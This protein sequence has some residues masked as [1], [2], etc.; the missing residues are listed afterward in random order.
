MTFRA[1]ILPLC[2]MFVLSQGTASVSAPPQVEVL[3]STA[4]VKVRDETIATVAKGEKYRLV[5][6]Q[7]PWVA[8]AIGNGEKQKQGWILASAVK[9]VADPNVTEESTAPDEPVEIRLT[10]DLTQFSTA[11]G[12]EAGVFFKARVTN[13]TAEPVQ[14]RVADLELK[15]DD[16]TLPALRLNQH[17]YYSVFLDAAMRT[18]LQP[19]ALP[20]LN[21]VQLAPGGVAEGWMAY[22]LSSLQQSLAQPGALASKTWIVDGKIGPHRIHLDLKAAEL[23]LL[24]EQARPSKV[25]NSVLVIDIGSRINAINE[26]RLFELIASVP[27]A[28]CG[29]VL[30]LKDRECLVDG[31][32]MQHF[33]QQIRQINQGQNLPVVSTEGR[34]EDYQSHRTFVSSLTLQ[35]FPAETT[36]VLKILGRRP[37]TG[38]ILAKYL[39]DKLPE[40]RVAA[41]LELVGHVAEEG[42]VEALVNAASD[43][44]P[45]VRSAAVTALGGPVAGP[46]TRQDASADTAVL[47]KAMFDDALEVRIAA[48]QTAAV[49]PCEKVR[50][51]LIRG[52][53][54]TDPM[55]QIETSVSLGKLR[56]RLAV[57]R[58]RELQRE[59]NPTLKMYAIDALKAIGELSSLE[60]A[61]AKL[62]GGYLADS[63][64]T[65][66]GQSKEQRAVEPLI[67]L[68]KTTADYRRGSIIRTLGEIGDPRA[69]DPLVQ[70]IAHGSGDMSYLPKALARLG[71]EKAVEPLREALHRKPDMP[72]ELRIA[73]LEGLL[74]LGAP[75][76]MEDVTAELRK[77]TDENT[78]YQ[79]HPLLE[80]LG[81]TN[82]DRAIPIIEPFLANEQTCRQAAEA[83]LL[84]KSK[85]SLAVLEDNLVT[86]EFQFGPTIIQNLQW[87]RTPATF[88]LLKHAAVRGNQVTSRAA[89]DALDNFQFG[90]AWWVASTALAPI[91]YLA[92]SIEADVWINGKA[93]SPAEIQG[94]VLLVSLPDTQG[95]NP[96]LSWLGNEWQSQFGKQGLVVVGLWSYSGWGWDATARQMEYSP[97]TTLEQEQQAITTLAKDRGIE[98]RVGVVP[99]DRDLGKQFGGLQGA[100]LAVIDRAGVLQAVLM[101][102]KVEEDSTELE[103]LLQELLEEPLPSPSVVRLPR[104]IPEPAVSF[105]EPKTDTAANQ[106]SSFDPAA[107]SW[108]IP[109]HNSKVWCV[110]FSPDGKV[111][112]S[113][114]EEGLCR[115]WDVAT[116]QLQHTLTGHSGL[117][118]HCQFTSDG[119]QVLTSGIDGTLR[120]WNVESGEPL[121]MLTDDTSVFYLTLL[122]DD[123]TLISASFDNRLRIWNLM[124]GK[125]EEHLAAHSSTVW[126]V[127]SATVNGSSVIVSGSTDRTARIWD[128]PPGKVRHTLS[129]HEMAVNAVAI[130]SSAK[131]VASGAEDGEVILW[132]A[133]TGEEDHRIP[134]WGPVVYDIAF[135]PDD[136]T[137]AVARGNH[138]VTLHDVATAAAIQTLNRGGWCVDFSNDGKL[139]VSGTD[140]G[141]L[142]V[143]K[144]AR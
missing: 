7:G 20:F 103:G 89:L 3:A 70:L 77:L 49:F 140:N 132:N 124:Q 38:A 131:T 24:G 22:S 58:L 88:T 73:I 144:L 127:S 9:I 135:A 29:C 117:A 92:P 47:L 122:G 139:L 61:L 75:D 42:V 33:Q 83:L 141:V 120:V 54:D 15:V 66:L 50:T 91:G 133:T 86:T 142:Q 6:T 87:P 79:L 116:G 82:D 71:D 10:I 72:Q 90:R 48:A 138:S 46:E 11:Y 143:W 16:E 94:K 59:S 65:E 110:R 69:V 136:K 45:A 1:I 96:D 67:A 39:D 81:R 111:I 78:Y 5:K 84:L 119:R 14:L 63:E 30:A 108:T 2:L 123:H 13:E 101:T 125:L 27:A 8:I 74:I 25:D 113:T 109:A 28:D 37:D 99:K 4:K 95:P 23:G 126:T 31:L 21:D 57:P 134:G 44:S 18:E 93:P 64:F 68:L 137:L 40:T 80:A 118:R 129:G 121:R 53:D 112:A 12:P 26:S 114:S 43:S 85:E 34:I 107:E 128:Y 17:V 32:A 130:T 106:F 100:R 62:D 41:A 55:V 104:Q 76:A 97:D 19:N 115:L 51:A 60:A 102:T 105:N 36:A 56:V 98:Y 35:S 52:L